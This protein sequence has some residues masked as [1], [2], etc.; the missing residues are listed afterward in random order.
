MKKRTYSER[1]QLEQ[2]NAIAD[3][4]DYCMYC[5][6]VNGIRERRSNSADNDTI[7]HIIR[8]RHRPVLQEEEPS[9]CSH[10]CRDVGETASLLQQCAMTSPRPQQAKASMEFRNNLPAAARRARRL[11]NTV[12]QEQP[13]A[14]LGNHLLEPTPTASG[15][16]DCLFEMDDL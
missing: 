2:A 11:S 5:R 8:T 12:I 1:R 13:P 4:R 10:W 6:I 7:N 14:I 15:E 3:Y 9:S 16:E